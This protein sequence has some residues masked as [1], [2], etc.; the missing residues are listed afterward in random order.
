MILA[1]KDPRVRAGIYKWIDEDFHG[2]KASDLPITTLPLEEIVQGP[3][4]FDWGL[5]NVSPEMAGLMHIY[6]TP[7]NGGWDE[8]RFGVGQFGVLVFSVGNE[9]NDSRIIYKT[10]DGRMGVY[11]SGK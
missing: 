6:Y 11:Y 8:I 2:K 7:G 3:Y 10:E 1:L 5:L 9:S 4:S